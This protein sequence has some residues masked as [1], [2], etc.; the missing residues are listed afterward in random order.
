MLFNCKAICQIRFM[1]LAWILKTVIIITLSGIPTRLWIEFYKLE[2]IGK[3]AIRVWK[4]ERILMKEFKLKRMHYLFKTEFLWLMM[5]PCVTNLNI[6]ILESN[7]C[8]TDEYMWRTH[9]KEEWMN[10]RK[11]IKRKKFEYWII[12]LLYIAMPLFNLFILH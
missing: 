8:K 2:E 9:W 10:W 5:N 7:G 12:L 3:M 1:K 11:G 6:Q 4:S